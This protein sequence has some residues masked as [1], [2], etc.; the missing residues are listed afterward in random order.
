MSEFDSLTEE[1]N[2]CQLL[3]ESD[4]PDDVMESWKTV[5][6]GFKLDSLWSFI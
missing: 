4:I 6:G 2:E 1:F 3:H 5:R